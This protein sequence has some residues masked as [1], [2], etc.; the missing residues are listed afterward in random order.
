MSLTAHFITSEWERVQVILNVKAMTGS[1][2]GQYISDLFLEL[3]QKWDIDPKRVMLVL[4][5]SGANVVKAMRVME[6]PDLSCCAHTLQL[7]IGDALGSQ[8]VVDDIIAKLKS[9]ATHFGHSLLAKQRLA[10]IQNENDVE[11]HS[12]LQATPTRWNSALIMLRRMLEQKQALILYAAEHGRITCPDAE[13]WNIV[14]KLIKTLTPIEDLTKE[15]SADNASISCI[16]PTVQVLRKYLEQL[17]E[18]TRGIQTFRKEMLTSLN[19]KFANMEKTRE[20]LLACIL[21]P[22]YKQRP[23]SPT[24]TNR[25]KDWLL[26]EAEKVNSRPSTT[27]SHSTEASCSSGTASAEERSS[28]SREGPSRSQRLLDSLYDD[29]LLSQDPEPEEP[30]ESLLEEL[31]RF[32]KEPVLDRKTGLLIDPLP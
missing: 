31:E 23:L 29:M 28:T 27:A 12:I 26:E 7:V 30:G 2:T 4:R 21:D 15:M 17:G 13:E 19:K 8:R 14:G 22:R 3:L 6:L 20:V 11:D 9:V 16:I 5:D 25:A 1:H 10:Q 32:W 18:D 24:A